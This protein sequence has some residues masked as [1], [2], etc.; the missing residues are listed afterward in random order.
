MPYKSHL[1][2]V[3]VGL[4]AAASLVALEPLLQLPEAHE[5]TGRVASI[6]QEAYLDFL[7]VDI[8]VLSNS[9]MRITE[10]QKYVFRSGTFRYGYRWIPLEKVDSIDSIAVYE[11]GRAYVRRRSSEGTNTDDS[12]TFTTWTEGNRLWI[13]WWYPETT[14][15]S[16]TFE[17]V[18]VVHGGLRLYEE[19]DQLYW[20]AVFRD[21]DGPVGSARVTVRLPEDVPLALLTIDSYGATAESSLIDNR[22][23]QFT[24]SSIAPDEGL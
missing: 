13:G 7:D 18:Y 20:Q 8:T 4:L 14:G 1:S 19:G 12:H 6:E 24:A 5:V 2:I 9:D 16:R 23:I 10:T 22:T 15:G 21:R 3:L 11:D 17:V